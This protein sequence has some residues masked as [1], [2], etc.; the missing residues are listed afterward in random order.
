MEKKLKME[1]KKELRK[2]I[3]LKKAG[4]STAALNLLSAEILNRL[5][6]LSVFQ[7][8]HTVLLYHSL[9][10]EV[11]THAFIEKWA[12]KKKILLPVVAGEN[13]ELH[14]Y[15]GPKDLRTGSYGISEPTGELFTAYETIDVAIIPGVAFDVNNHRLGRGKGYYDRL[16]PHIPAFKIGL[17]FPFQIIEDIPTEKTDISMDMIHSLPTG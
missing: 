6:E 8:A 14:A 1:K 5:E 12:D 16:L 4:Y 9:K 17:C 2:Q 7:E 11:N 10:D 15:T 13:L 3:A